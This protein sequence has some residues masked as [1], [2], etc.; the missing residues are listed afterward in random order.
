M[1]VRLTRSSGAHIC[2]RVHSYWLQRE[3]GR[4]PGCL[5]VCSSYL[6]GTGEAFI[7]L[8]VRTSRLI[9]SSPLVITPLNTQCFRIS[10]SLSAYSA[11]SLRC[12][13]GLGAALCFPSWRH[14]PSGRAPPISAAAKYAQTN[15]RGREV[16]SISARRTSRSGEEFSTLDSGRHNTRRVS[17]SHQLTP[18]HTTMLPYRKLSIQKETTAHW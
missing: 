6:L 16:T 2:P 9:F 12:G 18:M 14:I 11:Q 10:H 17:L 13:S 4:C 7:Q 15:S 3:H 8:S 1:C 5:P